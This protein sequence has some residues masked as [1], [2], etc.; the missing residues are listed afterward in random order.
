MS[1]SAPLAASRRKPNETNDFH[2]LTPFVPD[3]ASLLLYRKADKAIPGRGRY[4]GKP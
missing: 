2:D 3:L 1:F 4:G